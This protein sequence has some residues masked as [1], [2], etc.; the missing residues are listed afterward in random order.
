[1]AIESLNQRL[2]LF[3]SI[4]STV[5][6]RCRATSQFDVRPVFC[7]GDPPEGPYGEN[8]RW[9]TSDFPTMKQLCSFNGH[10]EANFGFMVSID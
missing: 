3:I 2:F 1:M 5:M 9:G 7:E 4:L 6:L 10:P 8:E